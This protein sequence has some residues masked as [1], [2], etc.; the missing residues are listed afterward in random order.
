MAVGFNIM[1]PSVM[2]E[3][4]EMVEWIFPQQ[5]L[6]RFRLGQISLMPPQ[7]YLLTELASCTSV[8]RLIELR[9][10]KQSRSVLLNADVNME[11]EMISRSMDGDVTLVLPFDLQSRVWRP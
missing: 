2:T 11:P 5:A 7:F 9:N 3:E 4:S 10:R 8:S 6:D 1:A